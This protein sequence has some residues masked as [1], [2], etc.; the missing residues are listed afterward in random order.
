MFMA[1]PRA[2][3]KKYIKDI[4]VDE[5]AMRKIRD[6]LYCCLFSLSLFREPEAFIVPQY[7]KG[8][9]T[10]NIACSASS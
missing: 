6:D 8:R 3:S 1:I 5:T 9:W 7:Q 10:V 4:T 2:W